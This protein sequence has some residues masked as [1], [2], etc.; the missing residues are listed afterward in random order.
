MKQEID[1]K[2]MIGAVAAV[3]VVIGI[4]AF[5]KFRPHDG[6][7]TATEAGMGRPM[8]AGGLSGQK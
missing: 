7:M 6:P 3:V 8:K 4:F 5:M 2:M 1:K